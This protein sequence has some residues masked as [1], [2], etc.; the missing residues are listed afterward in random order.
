MTTSTTEEPPELAE[1]IAGLSEDDDEIS[2]FAFQSDT[3]NGEEIAVT[4]I[5]QLVAANIEPG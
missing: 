5:P 3:L 4:S 1:Q 2:A